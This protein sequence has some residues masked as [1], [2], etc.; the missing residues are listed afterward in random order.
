MTQ[1]RPEF[2]FMLE[3]VLKLAIEEEDCLS[4]TLAHNTDD[5]VEITF[6]KESSYELGQDCILIRE[7]NK[8]EDK[9]PYFIS[10]LLRLND[11]I[12]CQVI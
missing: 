6:S 11:I 7:Y 9:D 10:Y 3:K 12:Y 1:E 5:P 8:L 2:V 4:F